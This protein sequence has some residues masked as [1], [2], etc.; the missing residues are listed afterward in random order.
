MAAPTI[1]IQKKS[2]P[3]VKKKIQEKALPLFQKRGWE[4]ASGETVTKTAIT[5]TKKKGVEPAAKG[6]EGL[7]DP[8]YVGS[9]NESAGIVGVSIDQLREEY[10]TISG[11]EPD[12]RWKEPRLKEEIE[13]LTTQK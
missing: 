2:N 12:K 9:D 1:Q 11:K 10:E 3:A 13:K 8:E 5:E 6:K 4:L 7:P